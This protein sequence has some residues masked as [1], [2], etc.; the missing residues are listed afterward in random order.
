MEQNTFHYIHMNIDGDVKFEVNWNPNNKEEVENIR[1]FFTDLQKQGY[2]LFKTKKKFLFLNKK[3]KIETF[4]PTLGKMIAELPDV[5]QVEAETE[6]FQNGEMVD[7]A[8][9]EF[10]KDVTYVSS[11]MVIGG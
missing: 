3:E 2:L 10:E 1:T 7:P 9:E 8:T 11:P 5:K 4:D 6:T